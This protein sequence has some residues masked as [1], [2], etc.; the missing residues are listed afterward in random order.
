MESL[1]KLS[2]DTATLNDIRSFMNSKLEQKIISKVLKGE[3][4]S[5]YANAYD[6]IKITLNEIEDLH[7]NKKESPRINQSE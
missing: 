1:V 7:K 3:D 6:I 4:V 5:G 2:Q